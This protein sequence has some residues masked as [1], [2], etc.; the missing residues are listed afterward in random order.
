MGGRIFLVGLIMITAETA[1][2]GDDRNRHGVDFAQRAPQLTVSPVGK[3]AEL[4]TSH[5]RLHI[6]PLESVDRNQRSQS[7]GVLIVGGTV[8]RPNGKSWPSFDSSAGGDSLNV[9]AFGGLHSTSREGTVWRFG[10]TVG[11]VKGVR[12]RINVTGDPDGARLR[13]YDG[14]YAYDGLKLSPGEFWTPTVYAEGVDVEISVPPESSGLTVELLEVAFVWKDLL[15]R[16]SAANDSSCL[17][18]FSCFA[19]Q[20]PS[21]NNISSAIAM[22]KFVKQGQ[23]GLCSGALINVASTVEFEPYVLTANHCIS[24]AAEASSAEFYFDARSSF[25]GGAIPSLGSLPRVNGSTVLNTNP[26]TDVSLLSMTTNPSG[27]PNGRWYLGWH[28]TDFSGQ[29]GMEIFRVAH[30][31]G[32]VQA[33]SRHLV[34]SVTGTCSGR[35]RGSY[36]YSSTAAGGVEAGSSGSPVFYL[37]DG[38]VFIVGQLLGQCG[39]NPS[40]GCDR[41]NQTVDGALIASYP[42]LQP[43]LR[44]DSS[45]PCVASSTTACLLNRR[46]RVTVRYRNAF[47]SG[48]VNTNALVKQ[49]SGFADPSYE[50][51]FFYFNNPNNIELMLKMLD[52]GNTNGAGQPTIAVLFGTAT[53]L[54]VELTITDTTRGTSKSYTSGFNQMKGVTDFTAFVK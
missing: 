27:G 49:V 45:T 37:R 54:G 48:A 26:A 51:A 11:D 23:V 24:T 9:P 52:Q 3:K 4:V 39:I 19:S 38:G 33:Y 29:E 53:P 44:P 43:W 6:N 46:F 17:L 30:P 25:C 20:L 36:I 5:S 7:G 31:A 35:P 50:T 18:D 41:L 2:I 34:R 1:T 16:E 47:D 10:V 40:N 42:G 32:R 14:V 21:G 28:A 15:S 22:I 12:L 13:L 8:T